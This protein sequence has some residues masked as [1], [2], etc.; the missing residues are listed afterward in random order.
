M[1]VADFSRL[2]SELWVIQSELYATNHGIFVDHGA[3]CLIDPGLTEASLERIATFVVERQATVTA[4]VLTHAHWDHL[5]GAHRFPDAQ[6]MAHCGFFD[7]IREHGDDLQKQIV[8]WDAE[9]GFER[10]ASFALPCPTVTFEDAMIVTVGETTIE[11]VHAPGHA[12]DQIAV[13][14]AES[15]ALWAADML[16]D[17]EIPLVS[18]SLSAYERTLATIATLD[19]RVLVPGHGAATNDPAEIERRLAADRAYLTELRARV[20]RVLDAGQS[21]QATIDACAEMSF[22]EPEANATAHQWNVESAYVE[23][24]GR[25]KGRVGWDRE[26]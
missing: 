20:K 12:P 26:W 4:V 16:S 24:G 15:G 23:L 7:V 21:L 2:T 13:Y 1:V 6:M 25:V 11:L 8:A 19:G 9:R 10:P 22:R 3:A 18:H 14:H 5:L 17:L